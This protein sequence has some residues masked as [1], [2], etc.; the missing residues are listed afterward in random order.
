MTK[1]GKVKCG[2]VTVEIHYV[3]PD[4]LDALSQLLFGHGAFLVLSS[5]TKRF[6]SGAKPKNSEEARIFGLINTML[7]FGEP[8]SPVDYCF[9]ANNLTAEELTTHKA[10][11]DA[12]KARL[13]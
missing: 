7:T 13:A 5:W 2:D 12:L 11:L 4:A 6:M 1:S 3:L 8:L 10:E 9:N